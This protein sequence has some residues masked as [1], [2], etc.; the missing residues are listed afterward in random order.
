MDAVLAENVASRQSPYAEWDT[1]QPAEVR[2][3]AGYSVDTDFNSRSG[4]LS[5]GGS[6]PLDQLRGMQGIR[7]G[8]TAWHEST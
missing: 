4:M 5:A 1:P 7:P 6:T 3:F 2:K 8:S